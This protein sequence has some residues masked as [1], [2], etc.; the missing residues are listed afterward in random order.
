MAAEELEQRIL[1]HIDFVKEVIVTGTDKGIEA[2]IYLD[3]D[4]PDAQQR[5]HSAI[6]ALNQKTVSTNRIDHIRLRETEF[7]KTTTKKIKRTAVKTESNM[8]LQGGKEH[9]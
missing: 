3:P 4:V 8:S 2:E 6:T 5:I 7:P 1:D 9:D